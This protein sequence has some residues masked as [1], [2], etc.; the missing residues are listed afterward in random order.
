[1]IGENRTRE[2]SVGRSLYDHGN[3]SI[4]RKRRQ[5]GV[6][7][8]LSICQKLRSFRWKCTAEIELASSQRQKVGKISYLIKYLWE[9]YHQWFTRLYT[10]RVQLDWNPQTNPTLKYH[11]KD[12]KTKKENRK[13]NTLEINSCSHKSKPYLG[14]HAELHI[15]EPFQTNAGA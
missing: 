8:G 7:V 1:M 9:A 5:T 3:R 15:F 14:N 4:T 10:K 13:R 12:G 6:K 11:Q 2:I